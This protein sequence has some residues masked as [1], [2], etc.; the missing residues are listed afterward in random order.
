M[1]D[2]LIQGVL[3]SLLGAFCCFGFSRQNIHMDPVSLRAI[4]FDCIQESGHHIQNREARLCWFVGFFQS[5]R[6]PRTT[7]DRKTRAVGASLGPDMKSGQPPPSQLT[8]MTSTGLFLP[9]MGVVPFLTPKCWL[10]DAFCSDD[11]GSRRHAEHFKSIF[12]GTLC[13][14]TGSDFVFQRPPGS[15][16]W[17]LIC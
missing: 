13:D 3:H 12:S 1:K 2:Y 11:D 16:F 9:L 6:A 4:N 14:R 7:C 15:E 8:T 10:G 17:V 5:S